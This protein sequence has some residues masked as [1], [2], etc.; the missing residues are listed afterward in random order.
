[1]TVLPERMRDRSK[2]GERGNGCVPVRVLLREF[3]SNEFIRL[4]ILGD[5]ACV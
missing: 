3:R 1:M 5:I 4:L 2:C